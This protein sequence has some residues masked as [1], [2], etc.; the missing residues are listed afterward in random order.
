MPELLTR[1][2]IETMER[3]LLPDFLMRYGIRRLCAE[4]LKEEI[5]AH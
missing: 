3:G 2:A 5:A 4:R 1:L